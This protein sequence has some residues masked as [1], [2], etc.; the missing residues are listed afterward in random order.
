VKSQNILRGDG[1]SWADHERIYRAHKSRIAG[2]CRLLLLDP[3][4]AD[5][6]VQDV[7]LRAFE[8]LR[9]AEPPEIWE[10]W[11]VRVAVNACR[12]RQRSGWWKS[13]KKRVEVGEAALGL[14]PSVEAESIARE[15]QARVWQ[16]VRKLKAQQRTVFVLRY[17]EG[18]STAEVATSLGLSAG[19]VKTH[20]FRA[21]RHL[22]KAL[23]R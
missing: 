3:D 8:R 15:R 6:V 16:Q 14:A 9:S 18:W 7:F 11:L 13:R 12:D 5:D 22:R 19:G 23:E 1:G 17:I 4:E 10:A 20:L 21:V 2:L